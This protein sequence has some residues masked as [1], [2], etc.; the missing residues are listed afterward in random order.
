MSH[1]LRHIQN[2]NKAITRKVK[3]EGRG[4][5]WEGNQWEE[6]GNQRVIVGGDMF[7]VHYACMKM[8]Q[9][10]SMFCTSDIC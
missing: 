7:R 9:R 10:N 1:V 4:I 6:E 5:I 8:S 2:R 3:L